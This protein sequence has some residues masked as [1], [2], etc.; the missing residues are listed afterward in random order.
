MTSV[1]DN[2][3]KKETL[4]TVGGNVNWRYGKHSH[5]GKHRFFK[6]LKIEIP[7]YPVISLLGIYPKKKWI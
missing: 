2:V 6:R 7:H 3:E 5:Y 4:C 1:C